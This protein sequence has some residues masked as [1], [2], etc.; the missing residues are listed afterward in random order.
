MKQRLTKGL[1]RK[2]NDKMHGLNTYKAINKLCCLLVASFFIIG[3]TSN[4]K[5]VNRIYSSN[6]SKDTFS[7]LDNEKDEVWNLGEKYQ[8]KESDINDFIKGRDK[9]S[10]DT[11]MNK[12]ICSDV[13]LENLLY[14]LVAA[15]KFGIVVANMDIALSLSE[16]LSNVDVST[17]SKKIALFYLEKWKNK[18]EHKRSV[19]IYQ[20]FKAKENSPSNLSVPSISSQST[21]IL[22]QKAL[23]LNG[24][25]DAY[26]E[27]KSQLCNSPMYGIL[28]YYAFIMA[29]RYNYKPA[30][31]DI[32]DI[33]ERFY[34]EYKLGKPDVETKYFCDFFKSK[35]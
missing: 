26:C 3:C 11:L 13:Y 14:A 30:K 6:T 7:I 22:K 4:I 15:D 28:L 27:L 12:F 24:S 29:D 20:A 19:E 10:Y 2:Y 16:G 9:E 32:I 17:N 34:K 5:G 31:A 35:D 18:S 21:E 25:V 1:M 8:L 23:C 33:I